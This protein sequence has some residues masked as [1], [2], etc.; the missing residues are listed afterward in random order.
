MS[1]I[2]VA[3]LLGIIPLAGFAIADTVPGQA[4]CVAQENGRGCAIGW[5]FVRSPRAFYQVEYLDERSLRWKKL[6]KPYSALHNHS[7]PVPGARLYRVRGCD[8]QTMRRN[9]AG[10]TVQWAISRPAP[11]AMPDHL[12]DGSGTEM[13][14]SKSAPYE[15]QVAQYNVYRLVQ[16]LDRVSDLSELPPMSRPS[17]VPLW[18]DQ[19]QTD[20]QILAGIYENYSERRRQ[21][22]EE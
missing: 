5:D 14:I 15:V 19:E 2:F 9:C 17:E 1:K 22:G 20:Q 13:Q 4:A 3:S 11:E 16:L 12:L 18:D 10:S 21:A 7:E 8:D 6:G